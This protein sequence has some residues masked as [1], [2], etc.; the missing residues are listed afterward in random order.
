MDGIIHLTSIFWF[1]EEIAPLER[2]FS[3]TLLPHLHLLDFGKA[4]G[5]NRY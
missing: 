3:A 5:Y 4:V 2:S 1:W